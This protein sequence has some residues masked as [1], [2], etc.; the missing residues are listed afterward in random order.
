EGGSEVVVFSPCRPGPNGPE[1]NL[2]GSATLVQLPG[3]R[4]AT[5]ALALADLDGDAK[6]DLVVG[7][8]SGNSYAI[9]VG[10]GV[11]DGSF[12]SA[13]PPPDAAGDNTLSV[14]RS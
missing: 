10:Y 7:A 14:L 1:L 8:R 2:N 4:V 5:R 3:G 11:G 6:L 13:D 9:T 12:H